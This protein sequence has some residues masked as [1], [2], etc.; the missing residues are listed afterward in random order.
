MENKHFKQ[1]S[2]RDL[3][4]IFSANIVNNAVFS[5]SIIVIVYPFQELGLSPGLVFVPELPTMICF[6]FIMSRFAVL[7]F[8]KVKRKWYQPSKDSDVSMRK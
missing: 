3:Q 4:L 1:D 7:V 2:L 6:A 8:L 5:F